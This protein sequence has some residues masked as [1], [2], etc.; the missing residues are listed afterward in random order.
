MPL[1]DLDLSRSADALFNDIM[2]YVDEAN[3]LVDARDTLALVGLDQAVEALCKRIMTLDIMAA[4]DY[5]EKLEGLMAAID[6][7]QGNIIA[8][9]NEVAT[10][11]NSLGTQKK[12]NRAY[13]NAPSGKVEE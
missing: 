3:A 13:N 11:L 7:L 12:A 2:A 5:T 4:K 9:Q 10:T 1:P 6:G 8:L